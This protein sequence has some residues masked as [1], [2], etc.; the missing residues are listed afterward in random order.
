MVLVMDRDDLMLKIAQDVAFT[1]ATV[2]SLAGPEGRVTRLERDQD[3]QWWFT[4]AVVQVL[5]L[6]HGVARKFGVNV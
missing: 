1:R 5:A 2:E 6:A 3:R 4:A